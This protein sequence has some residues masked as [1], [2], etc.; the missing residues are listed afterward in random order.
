MGVN[1]IIELGVFYTLHK[2]LLY[3]CIVCELTLINTH[4]VYLNA[5]TLSAL[6]TD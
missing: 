5:L 6:S 1:S 3:L 4:G 2:S